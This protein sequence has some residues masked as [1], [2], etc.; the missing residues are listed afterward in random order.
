MTV[1]TAVASTATAS[2]I[3]PTVLLTWLTCLVTLGGLLWSVFKYGRRIMQMVEDFNGEPERP[4]VPAR[5]GVMTRLSAIEAEI[6]PNHGGS[7]KD[8]V[9][10]IDVKVVTLESDVKGIHERL[11]SGG[12]EKVQ[13]NVHT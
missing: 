11:D 2:S 5:P 10:R 6:T 1:L 4:G 9:N 12:Q 13:V 8:A 7:I 3:D